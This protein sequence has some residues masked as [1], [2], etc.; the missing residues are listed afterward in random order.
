MLLLIVA[1]VTLLV[2]G[3]VMCFISQGALIEGVT[4]VRRG[5]KLSVREG[6]RE[7]WSHAGVIFKITLVY[8]AAN[9]AS[10]LVLAAPA[11]LAALWLDSVFAALVFA[12]P[13]V[14]VGVPWLVTLYIW[15]A[16]AMRITVL[17][18]RGALDAIHKTRLFLHGRLGQGLRSLVAA[19]LGTLLIT[20]LGASSESSLSR[21]CVPS[22]R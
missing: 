8:Y 22:R 21:T 12:I 19:F 11:L 10:L 9:I 6:F 3:I 16:F 2:G 14:V 1:L 13:G 17:E 7:G 5:A 15:R 4:R 20:V 18:N